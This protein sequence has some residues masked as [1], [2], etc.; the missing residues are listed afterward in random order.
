MVMCSPNRPPAAVQHGRHVSPNLS[1][2]PPLSPF[3]PWPFALFHGRPSPFFS[4][5]PGTK[6]MFSRLLP[7]VAGEPT[8]RLPSHRMPHG[9]CQRCEGTRRAAMELDAPQCECPERLSTHCNSS[10][11]ARIDG[12]VGLDALWWLLTNRRWARGTREPRASLFAGQPGAVPAL[13]AHGAQRFACPTTSIRMM[14]DEGFVP[15][16]WPNTFILHA[17]SFI[18]VCP[19]LTAKVALS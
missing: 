14:T 13:R 18:L 10:R 8:L 7:R 15:R 1:R 19:T 11:E 5:S 6:K 4:Q 12:T 9:G 16:A 3:H 17:S 2:T